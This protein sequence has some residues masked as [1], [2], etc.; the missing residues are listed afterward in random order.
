M[1]MYRMTEG[2]TIRKIGLLVA[3]VALATVLVSCTGG[4]GSAESAEDYPS[5]D[6]TL[7]VPYGAG[8]PTDLAARTVA[9]YY[10]NEFDQTILVENLAGAS[11]AQAMNEL[12]AS[13]P[14]GYTI[15]IIAAP[16]TV[17]VPLIED[18]GY[19]ADDFST[20]GVI[21]EIPSVLAVRGD[22]DYE[23]AEDFFAAAE[24]NPGQLNV[25]TAGANTSQGLEMKRLAEEYGIELSLVPFEGNAAM[26]SAL[27][28]G[29]VDAVFIN[30][31]EDVLANI[32][33][34]EFRPLAVSPPERVEYLSEVP[35][36]KEVGY[37]ELT[38]SVSIFGLAAPNGTPEEI[39]GK[40]ESTL[41]EALQDEEV[42]SQLGE[43]Y[44]PEEFVGSE[45]FRQRLND[46]VE[47]YRPLLEEN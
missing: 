11:G 17:V 30:A 24:E 15:A 14:D 34:G 35:T 5:D 41:Q 10:E 28:G 47:A 43:Q 13:Q 32:E 26:T 20:V 38:N 39:V 27:L 42:R 22:S 4:G 36:L 3:L 46:I 25:G 9:Q 7:L 21:T 2:K 6:V 29:N 44:V 33:G 19:T 16:A 18:V 8:G 1:G 40:L 23:T 37:E 31:S 12:I 45:E